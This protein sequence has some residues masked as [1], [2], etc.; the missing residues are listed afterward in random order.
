M[1][2]LAF[3][4]MNLDP[5]MLKGVCI[6]ALVLG[7]LG[8]Y[9]TRSSFPSISR[10]A[11][12]GWLA[13]LMPLS[14]LEA[15]IW[16]YA[17]QAAAHQWLP[18][19]IIGEIVLFIV[20]GYGFGPV[21]A[22]RSNNAFGTPGRW[23]FSY[24]PFVNL[25]MFFVAS[26]EKRQAG[27]KRLWLGGV[28]CVVLGLV[29]YGVAAQVQKISVGLVARAGMQE[30]TRNPAYM[31]K[32]IRGSLDVRPLSATLTMMASRVTTPVR[33]DE[34]TVL[35]LVEANDD[36]LRYEYDV[37]SPAA[38]LPPEVVNRIKSSFCYGALA[39]LVEDGATI[40]A[41]YSNSAKTMMAD[42]DIHTDACRALPSI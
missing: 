17:P 2:R 21:L 7:S 16:V 1:E 40:K 3:A 35:V 20:I 34:A 28:G 12:V 4:Y 22:G 29:V 10:L 30:G 18:A 23:W 27:Q 37:A 19:M 33:V 24:V 31:A 32:M 14:A 8:Y 13:I 11:Y 25:A 5:W 9:L 36:M 41:I 26:R 38:S 42:L 39:P 6:F 15:L